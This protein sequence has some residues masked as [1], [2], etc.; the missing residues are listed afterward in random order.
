MMQQKSFTLIELLV[1]IAI[2]GLL[3]SIVFISLAGVRARARDARILLD[4]RQIKTIAAMINSDYNSYANLCAVDLTLNENAPAPYGK[5]L[6]LIED[7]LT[8]Q[9]GRSPLIMLC[10]A[11]TSRYCVSAVSSTFDFISEDYHSWF[12]TDSDGRSEFRF[13]CWDESTDTPTDRC[14]EHKAFP[15]PPPPPP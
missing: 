7:D 15:P 8:K 4:L 2:I 11:A 1:V 9:Q 6:E 12:C 5:Q 14:L 13:Y 10:V 3:A